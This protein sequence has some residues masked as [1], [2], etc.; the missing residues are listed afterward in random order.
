MYDAS[1]GFRLRTRFK[2]CFSQ[3]AMA[4]G[5][6]RTFEACFFQYAMANDHPH[7]FNVTERHIVPRMLYL[8]HDPGANEGSL[9]QICLFSCHW[10]KGQIH[11]LPCLDSV[12]SV[13]SLFGLLLALLAA[14]DFARWYGSD[15]ER[16]VTVESIYIYPTVFSVALLKVL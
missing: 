7:T 5:L 11:I 15:V 13:S 6:P 10:E 2:A 4:N 8:S 14:D 12:T 1:L 9:A 16:F 3:Y